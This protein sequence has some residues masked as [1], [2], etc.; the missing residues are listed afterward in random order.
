LNEKKTGKL[1][2][3]QL[4]AFVLSEVNRFVRLRRLKPHEFLFYS[5]I[6]NREKPMSRQWAHRTIARMGKISH[7]GRVGTHSMRKTYACNLFRSTGDLRAV[8]RALNHKYPSTTLMYLAD[9]IP[10]TKSG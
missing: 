8:Q 6:G 5:S 4:D 1:R 7:V 10:G 2:E 9:L 3:I